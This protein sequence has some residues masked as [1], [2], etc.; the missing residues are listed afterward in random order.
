[1]KRVIGVKCVA[2]VEPRDALIIIARICEMNVEDVLSIAMLQHER[3]EG[4]AIGARRRVAER[5]RGVRVCVAD[6]VCDRHIR[7][8]FK[9]VQPTAIQ[10]DASENVP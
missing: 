5:R 7:Q 10:N 2:K 3:R 9:G 6:L 1:M 8:N 4:I